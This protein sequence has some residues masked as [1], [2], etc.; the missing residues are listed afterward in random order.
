MSDIEVTFD[1]DVNGLLA[2]QA[3][4]HQT[5]TPLA[6]TIGNVPNL[7]RQEV[8]RQR[9]ELKSLERADHSIKRAN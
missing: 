3:R 2:I 1:L 7:S 8:D 4:D 6:V 9:N 5:G